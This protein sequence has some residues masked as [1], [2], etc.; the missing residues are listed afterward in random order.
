MKT[1]EM[2]TRLEVLFAQQGVDAPQ[3][4]RFEQS[5]D[6]VEVEFIDGVG[7]FTYQRSWT[8]AEFE[9]LL[10]MLGPEEDNTDAQTS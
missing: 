9:A 10:D 8:L 2:F 6:G 1:D 4:I 5:P 3:I 7:A